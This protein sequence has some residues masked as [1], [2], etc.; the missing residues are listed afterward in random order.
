MNLRFKNL[1]NNLENF[2]FTKNFCWETGTVKFHFVGKVLSLNMQFEAD[3]GRKYIA[4]KNPHLEGR[5]SLK[6]PLR[7]RIKYSL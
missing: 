3:R 2:D 7:I 5:R 6:K 1:T 4:S